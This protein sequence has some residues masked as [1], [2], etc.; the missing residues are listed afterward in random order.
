MWKFPEGGGVF[1]GVLNRQC[2][3]ERIGEKSELTVKAGAWEQGRNDGT[4]K[5]DWQFTTV[6]AR[7][8]LRRLYP[9]F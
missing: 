5:I 2:V 7:I 4:A 6:D 3:G 9:K 8:K 1:L